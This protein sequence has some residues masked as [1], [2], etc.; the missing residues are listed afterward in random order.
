MSIFYYKFKV[1]IWLTLVC[2]VFHKFAIIVKCSIEWSV[3]RDLEGSSEDLITIISRHIPG[4]IKEN[5]K[6]II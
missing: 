4:G 1:F 5:Y 3:G 6:I 2:D